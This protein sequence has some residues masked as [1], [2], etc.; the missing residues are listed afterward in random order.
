MVR[1]IVRRQ[2]IFE[3]L[4]TGVPHGPALQMSGPGASQGV[5]KARQGIPRGGQSMPGHP[6]G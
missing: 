5:D 3:L 2:G 4:Q 1:C 6:K